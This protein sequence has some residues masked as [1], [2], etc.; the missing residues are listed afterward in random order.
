[1]NITQQ[2]ISDHLDLSQQNVSEF[3]KHVDFDWRTASLDD[4]R[5]AYIRKLRAQAAGHR[6]EDGLDLVRERVLTERIDRELKQYT[7]AEKKG[8]LVNVSQLESELM[9]MVGAFRTELLSR[10]DK[11]KDAIDTLYGIDTDIQL[12]NEH[13]YAALNHLARYDTSRKAVSGEDSHVDQATGENWADTV[14]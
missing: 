8:V 13:T 12:L 1:M 11:F 7:L 5:Y 6:S 2:Q 4:I 10:Y 14:G 9:E 3:L